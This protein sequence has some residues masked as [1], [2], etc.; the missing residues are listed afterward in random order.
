MKKPKPADDNPRVWTNT[1]CRQCL[2]LR[3]RLKAPKAKHTE[4][5]IHAVCHVCS[6]HPRQRAP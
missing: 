5:R 6:P 4:I 1:G 3:Y 2:K